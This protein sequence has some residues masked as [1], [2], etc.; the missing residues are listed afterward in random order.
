MGPLNST[1]RRSS[2]FL[3]L[4]FFVIAAGLVSLTAFFGMQVP[5]VENKIMSQQ[6]D[7]F[8]KKQIFLQQFAGK[9][10]KIRQQLDN[11]DK[12]GVDADAMD[13]LIKTN[14]DNLNEMVYA[15]TTSSQ[16]KLFVD[17]I[18]GF[19]ALKKAKLDLRQCGNSEK[20]ID[21]LKDQ[22]KDKSQTILELQGTLN[23]MPKPSH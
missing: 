7:T 15:D 23:S 5:T 9:I 12:P 8:Q 13:A 20:V 1:E 22:I 21:G 19:R 4:I 2:F 18:A 11:I 14:L 6:I 16:G 17:V 10:S 3:F